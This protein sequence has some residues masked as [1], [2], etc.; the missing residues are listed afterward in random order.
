MSNYDKLVNDN[1]NRAL[2]PNVYLEEIKNETDKEKKFNILKKYFTEN[3]TKNIYQNMDLLNNTPSNFDQ[4]KKTYT[5]I[6][7]DLFFNILLAA[8]TL[9]NEKQVYELDIS[10]VNI[11]NNNFN[12]THNEPCNEYSICES[13]I[14]SNHLKNT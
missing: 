3:I 14:R 13:Y 8:D 11:Q 7:K 10:K 9:I 1:L 2:E 4:Y 6:A 12:I 5:L